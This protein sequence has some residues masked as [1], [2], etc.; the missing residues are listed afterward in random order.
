[1]ATLVSTGQFTLIDQN[2][3]RSISSLLI[4]NHGNQQ[5]TTKQDSEA[6]TFTPDWASTNL[7]ITPIISI[8]GLTSDNAWARISDRKFSLTRGGTAITNA[9]ANPSSAI[10]NSANVALTTGNVFGVLNTANNSISVPSLTLKGNL[11]S[12]TRTFNIYF[13][14]TYTDPDTLLSTVIENSITLS[15]V[16]TGTN[17]TYILLRGK[18]AI[19]ESSTATKNAIAISADLMR[20]SVIDTTGLTYKWY[21]NNGGTQISTSTA[22]YATKY[23][24]STVAA[25]AVPTPV[26]INGTNIP[27]SGTGNAFNTL[28]L[29]EIAVNDIG[30]FRVDIS[31]G[32]TTY[33]STFTV[34]DISDPYDTQV[35]STAGDKLQNGIGSTILT[36]IVYNGATKV[37]SL[38]GW[39]FTWYMYDKSGYRCG[40]VDTGKISASGGA[41][42]TAH[43]SGTSAQ[44]TYGGT[45]Y[46]F[47]A[48][49]IIKCV[50][51]NGNAS[52]YEVISS[53]AGTVTIRTPITNT[54][55]SFTNYPAPINTTEFVNGKLFG[56]TTGGTR[57]VTGASGV[58]PGIVVTGDDVDSKT[59][60]IVES[61]RP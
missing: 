22:D 58:V 38:D 43:S 28:S 33:S 4:T 39:S 16:V 60:I 53:A 17:A 36:P 34:Y 41:L 51:P 23:A 14:C 29:S 7:T 42:I 8:G 44:F 13:T 47:V 20:G 57:T 55:L 5:V 18:L 3:A 11:S 30:V 37:S 27:V 12:V 32:V 10:V 49:D 52:Y 25:P 35:L 45:S 40:F 2:D 61:N 6:Q 56:C 59:R 46:A 21:D 15:S 31:D 19:E 54:F 9:D 48:G 24:L 1:M 50:R 26:T